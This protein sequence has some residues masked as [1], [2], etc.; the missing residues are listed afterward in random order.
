MRHPHRVHVHVLDEPRVLVT[1]RLA[2]RAPRI[3]PEAVPVHALHHDFR[4]VQIKPVVRAQLDGAKTKLV[5][6]RVLRHAVFE[7]REFHPIQIRRLRRP[8]FHAVKMGLQL[9]ALQE[10]QPII[11]YS[12][13]K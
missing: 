5:G 4:A 7:Q 6:D 13:R 12:R 1:Q 10:S 8:Q 2:Q 3:R 11:W 9:D